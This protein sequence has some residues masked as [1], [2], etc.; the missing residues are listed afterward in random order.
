MQFGPS[1]DFKRYPR[2][3]RRDALLCKHAGVD[4][5][6]APKD[7]EMYPDG[8]TGFSTFVSEERLS[9]S[10]EGQARPGH[11]RGVTTVVAKLFNLVDP[12]LAVFG[13]KDFQQAAVIRRMVRDLNFRTRVVV[14]PTVREPDGLAMSSRN[15]YL[16]PVER[17]QAVVLWQSMQLARRRVRGAAVGCRAESLRKEVSRLISQQPAARPEYIAFFDPVSLE[18][19]PTVSR[20]THMA[21]AVWIGRT[22]LIDNRRL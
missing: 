18:P 4:I 3:L 9:Q 20:G 5:V 6:F 10:M 21:L 1:E 12:D 15:K 8:Q 11:F 16:S 22:R 13:Q 2:D 17:P 14:A 7:Q 19:R